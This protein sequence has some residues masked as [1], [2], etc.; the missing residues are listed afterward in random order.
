MVIEARWHEPRA[1]VEAPQQV[2][3]DRGP[4]M[5]AADDHP[6]AQRDPARPHARPAVDLAFA[7]A[8]LAGAAHETPRPV[9][10]EAARQG[11]PPGREQAHGN[12]LAPPPRSGDRRR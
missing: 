1:Q 5:L 11:P 8:A 9:E 2:V 10:P 4:G 12:R 7:P 3:L 6:V